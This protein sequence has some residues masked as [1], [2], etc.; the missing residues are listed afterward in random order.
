MPS[1]LSRR[2][3]GVLEPATIDDALPVLG[4]QRSTDMSRFQLVAATLALLAV[5]ACT[6]EA[7][8]AQAAADAPVDLQSIETLRTAFAS[9][10][11]VGNAE[12]V[13][14]LY[15]DDAVSQTNM[16]PTATGRAAIIE[17]LAG[18]FARYHV[19]LDI[20]PD[21]THTLGN[22]GWE[23]GR[24]AMTLRPKRD[25]TPM[26][27][28]GRYMIVV[29]RTTDGWKIARDIDNTATPPPAAPST[30]PEGK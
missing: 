6:A 28:D 22:T 27:I 15:T 5:A 11:S 2:F 17:S 13:G 12:A 25:G 4:A 19:R 29:E 8:P 7:P 10:Y 26:S 3:C 21:E 24:Y 16:Q 30:A 23:R 18:T 1:A 9:A 14:A 20:R